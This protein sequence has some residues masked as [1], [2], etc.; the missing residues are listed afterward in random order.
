[1]TKVRDRRPIFEVKPQLDPFELYDMNSDVEDVQSA[2]MK[3]AVL[4]AKSKIE[5]N[6]LDNDAFNNADDDLKQV[7]QLEQ[8]D[9]MSV[10]VTPKLNLALFSEEK[11][12]FQAITETYS[13][14]FQALIVM[15]NYYSANATEIEYINRRSR[16]FEI[17]LNRSVFEA[18]QQVRSRNQGSFPLK[19]C[20]KNFSSIFSVHQLSSK[21][22]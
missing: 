18:K 10:T 22:S 20:L 15:L 14:I 5:E 13:K 2:R 4:K 1:M 9:I 19:K 8:N 7:I 11:K 21:L 16:E 3:L 17:R 12:I 6:E